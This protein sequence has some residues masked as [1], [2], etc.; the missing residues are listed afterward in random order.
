MAK[1]TS[2]T[3]KAEPRR[4]RGRPRAEDLAEL[5]ASLV[6]VARERFTANGYGAT[7]MNAVAKAARVSKGTLYARFPSKADLFRAIIEEQI[8]RSSGGVRHLGP[9]PKTL[10]AMLRAFAER[11]LQDSL[12]GEIVQLNRLIYSEAERFPELGEAA[13]ARSRVGVQQVSEIIREY[14]AKEGVSCREP[15]AAAEMF[16]TLLRGFYGDA[17]LRSRPVAGAEIKVWTRKMVKVFLN[18]RCGW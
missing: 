9:K 10:E 18:G 12:Q 6:R 3:V 14:A 15:E 13:W 11:A 1:I 2:T 4:A 7:S 5:E 16:T 8:Q 17:M